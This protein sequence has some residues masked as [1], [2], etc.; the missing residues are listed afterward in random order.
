MKELILISA[1]LLSN[2]LFAQDS[3]QD[4]PKMENLKVCQVTTKKFKKD[5]TKC[6]KGDIL[7]I[8][9]NTINNPYGGYPSYVA[10]ACDLDTIIMY[11][12]GAICIFRG[13]VRDFR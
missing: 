1:L 11:E 8:S 4:N 9:F 10:K 7:S 12:Y 2:P 13:Y 3:I 6:E 5:I